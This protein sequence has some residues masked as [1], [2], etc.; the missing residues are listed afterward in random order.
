MKIL[1]ITSALD[2]KLSFG[3]T[4]AWWQLFKGLYEVGVDIVATPYAGDAVESPWWHS[5]PNPCLR[6]SQLFV[7][8]KTAATRLLGPQPG[9]GSGKLAQALVRLRIQPKWRR[10]ISR[11]LE[12]DSDISTVLVINVPMNH[13]TGLPTYVRDR[14]SLP[15]FYLD[16]DM[17]M[18]LP[19]FGGYASGVRGY[20]GADLSEYDAIITNSRAAEGEL[21]RLG[22]RAAATL[23]FG[24]DP[25]L[26]FPI[27]IA[28][29]D[30]DVFFYGFGSEHREEDIGRMIAGPSRELSD[31]RFV[32]GGARL[33]VD[34]GRAEL[35]G[36]VMTSELR[37]YAARAKVNLNIARKPHATFYASSCM[38]LF[39]LA[40]LGCCIVT[41][42]IEGL[43][44]WFEPGRE[45][46]VAPDGKELVQFYRHLL[47]HPQERQAMAQA[48]R[49]RLQ[50]EHTYR[51]RARTL[52]I[53]F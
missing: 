11:I 47:A 23:P 46:L 14:F 39:E 17:P 24:A 9:S 38:R 2:L 30:I 8:A 31:A 20:E 13:F 34:L 18:S 36:A 28:D 19:S 48:A 5:Y 12:R 26:F 29:Q 33:D 16:G 21:M 15:V 32:V 1:A 3:A 52:V 4:S 49:R 51:H 43:D 44:Q 10:H 40:A 25:D 37:R 6:E 45:L 41:N 22:A 53:M 50:E 35:L 42:A 7:A 27:E